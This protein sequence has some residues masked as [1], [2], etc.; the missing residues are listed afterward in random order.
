MMVGTVVTFYSY[1]GGV[2]RTFALASTAATLC[3]WGYRTLCIDWDLDA[4]GLSSYFRR[5]QSG[6]ARRGLVDLIHDFASGRRPDPRQYTVPVKVPG[7]LAPLDLVPAGS[8]DDE[9]VRRLQK[10]DWPALYERYGFGEFLEGCRERWA[11]KYDFVLVDSRTG[12]TDIG[13]ICTAQLPEILIMMLTANEQSLS[14]TMDVARRAVAARD[15]LPYDRARLMIVPV[16]TRFDAREEYERA[17]A[18]QRRFAEDLQP[19]VSN[20]APRTVSI[21]RLLGHLTVPY[22]SYWSFGEELPALIEPE[23]SPDKINYSLQSL[24]AL[25]AHR[26]DRVNLLAESRDSYVSAAAR[27]ALAQ[28]GAKL[29]DVLV[30]SRAADSRVAGRLANELALHALRTIRLEAG[31]DTDAIANSRNLV[32]LVG[33]SFDRLQMWEVEQFLRQTL[34]EESD[35]RV[36]PVLTPDGDYA[37][38]PN[39]LK[40]FMYVRLEDTGD[41][42]VST[43]AARIAGALRS[44]TS[45]ASAPSG[46]VAGGIRNRARTALTGVTSWRLDPQ[47][48]HLVTQAVETIEQALDAHDDHKLG[49]A[50]DE[51]ELLGSFWTA[52][53]DPYQARSIPSELL[54]RVRKTIGRL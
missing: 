12:I 5:W 25:L 8:G 35:R 2:G 29:Y 1:K 7:G 36:I 45:A 18:W 16:P 15:G 24:A 46:D 3:R 9:Y 28:R 37:A 27:V 33:Q 10:L 44:P 34:D 41:Y 14:G 48:W 54:A 17:A 38:L 53:R 50:I 39:I 49:S 21:E 47:R 30:S 32:V 26:L 22:I 31:I 4:P 43:L 6:P 11:D 19:L 13:G 52:R 20:W 51:L 40:H 23:P 42:A